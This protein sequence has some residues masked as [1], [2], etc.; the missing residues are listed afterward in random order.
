MA[1]YGSFKTIQ[2][3]LSEIKETFPTYQP[4]TWKD[5]K[6]NDWPTYNR[7][8][9]PDKKWHVNISVEFHTDK[10]KESVK[11]IQL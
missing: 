10:I 6:G 9:S 7:W 3:A 11:R 2:E 1:S 8:L 5:R 4:E